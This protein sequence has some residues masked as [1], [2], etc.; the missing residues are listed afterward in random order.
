[1]DTFKLEESVKLEDRELMGRFVHI[2]H[3]WA[4]AHVCTHEHAH[5]H[6]HVHTHA[7][8]HIYTEREKGSLLASRACV[9][10]NLGNCEGALSTTLL[11]DIPAHLHIGVTA[12]PNPCAHGCH[13]FQK[14]LHIAHRCHFFPKSLCT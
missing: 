12:S 5:T 14:F 4:Q 11:P 3:A 6:T 1:M 13:C 7:Y 10:G 8:T 9:V 2:P